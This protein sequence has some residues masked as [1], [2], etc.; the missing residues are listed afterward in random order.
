MPT[1]LS[2]LLPRR[3]RRRTAGAAVA[4]PSSAGLA[5][6]LDSVEVAARHLVIGGDDFV[7]AVAVVG[8]AAEVG[9]AFLD[10]LM[11]YPGRI[12]VALHVD[13]VPAAV[14]AGRLKKQRARLES[15]RRQDA[16]KGRL[17]DPDL[18]AAAADAADLAARLA[19][20]DGRL[21]RIGIYVTVHAASEAE[22][23]ERVTEVRALAASLLLDTVPT[24]WRPLQ[25]WVCTMPLATD[26]LN[27]RRTFD[28]SAL[29]AAFPFTS[30]D[31]P[32][33]CDTG[34]F[35][36]LNTASSGVVVWDRWKQNNYNS[37]ALGESGA[38]KSFWGKLDLLRNLYLGAE[39]RA[40][41]TAD[42]YLGLA[43]AVGGKVSRPG[44]AGERINPFDLVD[45]G[46]GTALDR[47]AQFLRTF[48][49]VLLG[50]PLTNGE[51]TVLDRAVRN[52]YDE[53][54]I[55]EDR[56]TWRRPVPLLADLARHLAD[57]GE[58]A[59][60]L[61]DRLYPYVSGS[62]RELFDGP[63][64]TPPGGHL[65]VYSTRELPDELKPVGTLL[66]LDAI[67]RHVVTGDPT[68]RKLVVVDEAWRLLSD[69][70]GALFLKEVAK[71]A[72]KHHAGLSVLT[73]DAADVLSTDAGRAVISNSATQVLLRQA[74]QAIDAV[75]AAFNLTAG[76]RAWLLSAGRGEALL[77]AGRTRVTFTALASDEFEHQL[78]SSTPPGAA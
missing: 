77:T 14:A 55:T 29:A 41:E 17:D 46:T 69:G 48:M 59:R 53:V 3:A 43:R 74:P 22:L 20:G 76:E 45:D 54:G 2:S 5:A 35:Y 67:R 33:D 10:P 6:G 68:V 73:Q 78:V 75:A 50:T 39:V 40:L 21:F 24:T 15:A 64:T 34:V 70:A 28:T 26:R 11:A 4:A 19:R 7:A 56:R 60:G 36:G 61:A 38:G 63:T 49:A 58:I 30:A 44:A 71:T 62:F 25:G 42:E 23:V 1:T 52:V 37:V 47:R 27:M 72:R 66:I 32:G 51:Q 16:A 12:E 57:G 18:D 31:L 9:G 65:V 8:Y 13:P